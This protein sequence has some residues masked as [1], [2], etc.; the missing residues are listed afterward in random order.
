MRF[1]SLIAVVLF[2][3]SLAAPAW[4]G[5]VEDC[6]QEFD[7]DLKIDGCTAVIL[8]PL[9]LN[10]AYAYNNR[11]FAYYNLG[12]HRRAI[13]DYDEALRLDPGYALAY[14]N[15][16][17]A[18]YLSGYT[19]QAIED[20][21]QAL[22]LNDPQLAH[23]FDTLRADLDGSRKYLLRDDRVAHG[24]VEPAQQEVG[25]LPILR[26]LD[27]LSAML[28]GLAKHDFIVRMA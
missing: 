11:G 26:Q 28:E 9:R 1:F 14:S 25:L 3:S 20:L 6:R 10:R 18:Y 8:T 22:R 19:A 21:D 4:A 16:G 15:R 13:Q 2:V 27:A 5:M 7:W 24:L 12:E 17:V 23:R